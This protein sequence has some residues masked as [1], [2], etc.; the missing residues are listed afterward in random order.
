MK[1]IACG[2]SFTYGS[3]P[4]DKSFMLGKVKNY[5][6]YLS[7]I[8][9]CDMENL[10]FPGC[11]N[12]GIAVQIRHAI[13]QKPDFIIF[14]TTTSMRYEVVRPDK[15]LDKNP[16]YTDFS[17]IDNIG[18][19]VLSAHYTIVEGMLE[20]RKHAPDIFNSRWNWA[21]FSE[22]H[23]E[24]I[25][26]YLV[27]YQDINIKIDQDGLIMKGI[28]Q[29]LEESGIPFVC[30]D[31]VDLVN[32]KDIELIK[33]PWYEYVKQYPFEQDPHHWNEDGHKALAEKLLDHL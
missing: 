10:A 1:G 8:A 23:F 6:E 13:Q 29:E 5:S 2:C 30:I 14:N 12:Y 25:Y 18:G 17:H 28:I 24:E 15:T 3:G 11:S 27:K 32:N 33:L 31:T 26:N 16:E 22:T 4:S 19:T 9:K 7:D 21:E 20:G